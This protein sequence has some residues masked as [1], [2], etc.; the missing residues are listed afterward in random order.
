MDWWIWPI[1]LFLFAILIGVLA[2]L[3]GVGGGVI[4]V[5]TATA[6][7]PFHVDFIRGAG[8][9]AAMTSALS[10]APHFA[11]RGLANLRVA[12]PLLIVSAAMSIVGGITSLWLTNAVKGG[13]DYFKIFLGLVLFLIFIVMMTSKRVEFPEVKKIDNLS[14]ALG[15]KGE[16]YEPSLDKTVEY[17]LTNVTKALPAF[18]GVGFIAGLFGLG[19]G[20]ANVPVL[21]LIMGAPIKVATSTSMMIVAVND[22]AA[23]WVYMAKGAILPIIVVPTVLGITI[24]VRIGARLAVRARPRIIRY[25]VLAVLLLSAILDIYKGLAG[26]GYVPKLF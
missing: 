26:L 14:K 23:A 20:W 17:H 24:G 21:N 10:S 22:A 7:F 6:F 25:I 19:A 1:V 13:A 8:L 9:I 11:R 15:L 12:A 4:F 5:P 3:S 16:W 18:A 2:P